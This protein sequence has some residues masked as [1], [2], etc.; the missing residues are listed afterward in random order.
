MILIYLLLKQL[1]FRKVH[2]TF[3]YNIFYSNQDFYGR[4][5]SFKDNGVKVMIALGG[6]SDSDSDKYSRLVSDPTAR[7]TFI[8]N[9][10][11]FI[12]TYKFDGLDLDWEFPRCW[13]V[14]KYTLKYSRL[15]WDYIILD[16]LSNPLSDL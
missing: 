15:I 5:T 8:D 7:Q 4:I 13:Q 1:L 14:H 16:I 9:A 2:I 10:I 3:F 12:E 11:T 6:W